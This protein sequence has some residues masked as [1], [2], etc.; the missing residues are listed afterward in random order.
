MSTATQFED[1]YAACMEELAYDSRFKKLLE[2]VR[3][4]HDENV[5]LR[6]ALRVKKDAEVRLR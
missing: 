5:Q 2:L 6:L 1:A 3:W 4:L